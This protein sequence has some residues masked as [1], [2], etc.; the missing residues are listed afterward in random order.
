MI[1]LF[2]IT[3]CKLSINPII[4]N[5]VYTHTYAR[6]NIILSVCLCVPMSINYEQM[7]NFFNFFIR[8][9]KLKDTVIL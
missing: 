1:Q 2:V 9:M 8:M 3:T 4:Q 7:D 6:D 5:T